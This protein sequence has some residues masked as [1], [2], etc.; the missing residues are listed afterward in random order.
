MENLLKIHGKCFGNFW[1]CE[2]C[3][4]VGWSPQFNN[5]HEIETH[6]S[7]IH[8]NEKDNKMNIDDK[9][10]R[11]VETIKSCDDWFNNLI[12]I[13]FDDCHERAYFLWVV[14]KRLTP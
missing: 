2:T 1:A 6:I 12:N 5:K 8:I 9:I 3:A 4:E 14:L 7:K 13:D 11:I 10:N